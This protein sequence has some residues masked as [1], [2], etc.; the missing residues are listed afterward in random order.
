MS[1]SQPL[2]D[3]TPDG[4]GD[5]DPRRDAPAFHRNCTPI[6]DTLTPRL[7]QA[8]GEVLEIGSGTGQHVA[9]FAL[10]FPTL[11]WRPSDPEPAHRASIDAWRA[12]FELKTVRPA[13]DLDVSKN[14]WLLTPGAP[15]RGFR[16]MLCFNVLHI[17]PWS[18]AS[19]LFRG[20]AK[21]LAHDGFLAL[22][23]PFRWHG[24]HVAASNAA[25]DARLRTQDPAWGVRDVDAIDELAAANDL[26][27][28][29]TETMPANNHMLFF[30]HSAGRR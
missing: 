18:V 13:F 23:G 24:R 27:R 1:K 2:F 16:A 25:F 8:G 17:A 12:H 6:L 21:W 22:Y 30:T 19:G 15:E 28:T 10:S 11:I 20:A 9:L 29:A 5:R 26:A 7:A 3:G 4:A 14:E